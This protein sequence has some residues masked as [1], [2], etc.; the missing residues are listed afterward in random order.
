MESSEDTDPVVAAVDDVREELRRRRERG[1]LPEL[2]PGELERQF[3]GVVEAV[4]GGLV[5]LPPIDPGDLTGP[6]VLET[7]RPF[8][9]RAGLLGRSLGV[10]VSPFARVIGVFV[11][12]QVGEF[13]TR[14][15]V[16]V[17][18]L[19][20]RQNRTSAFLSR[21][22]L[23]RQRR[24]EYRCAQLELEVERLRARLDAVERSDADGTVDSAGSSG[25]GV[26]G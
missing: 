19:A 14:T 22:F 1:E 11:R 25:V 24:L 6:A 8:R 16:V 5:E 10:L 9:G 23:D 7:W 15:A 12:R 13:T 4:E 26:D 17:E 21:A 20:A 18:E 3:S 2:P